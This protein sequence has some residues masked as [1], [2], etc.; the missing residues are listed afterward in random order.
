MT[1]RDLPFT[2]MIL[3]L[4]L[5]RAFTLLPAKSLRSITSKATSSPSS[6]CALWGEK[7]LP[8][9]STTLT[10]FMG[11][12][13]SIESHFT[14]TDPLLLSTERTTPSSSSKLFL[15][16]PPFPMTTAKKRS[17][18]HTSELQSLAYL[19]CRLLLEKKKK[20]SYAY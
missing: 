18:E 1:L 2:P 6:R 11:S 20:R 19:V 3:P 8:M 4:I 16:E 7:P 14:T 13:F 17:E 15:V 9:A 10:A 5:P 12:P